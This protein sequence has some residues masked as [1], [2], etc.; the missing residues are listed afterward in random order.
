LKTGVGVEDEDK[1]EQ[2]LSK[3]VESTDTKACP[4]C[5]MLIEKMNDDDC[6]N[7]KCSFC[8]VHLCWLCLD[9]SDDGMDVVSHIRDNHP[10]NEDWEI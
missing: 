2:A 7:L 5:A 9:N 1:D 8:H 3:Y 4:M 6:Y 10:P